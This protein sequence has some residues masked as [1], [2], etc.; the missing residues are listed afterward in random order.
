MAC[1]RRAQATQGDSRPLRLHSQCESASA[2]LAI[3]LNV[4]SPEIHKS[5]R[6]LLGLWPAL[7]ATRRKAVS[8]S[9]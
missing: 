6:N 4:H 5:S 7:R 3:E 9:R 8:L 1:E 2:S